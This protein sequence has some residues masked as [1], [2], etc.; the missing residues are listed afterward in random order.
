M[1]GLL[2]KGSLRSREAPG[3]DAFMAR[4]DSFSR[5]PQATSLLG[6]DV[7]PFLACLST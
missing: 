6:R 4:L 3:F 2:S 1:G 5:R 7:D